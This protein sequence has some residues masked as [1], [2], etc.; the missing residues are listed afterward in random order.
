[1]ASYM[2][3]FCKCSVN[4]WKECIVS[5]SWLQS[6]AYFHS[7]KL[8]DRDAD[9][10]I[11]EDFLS[12]GFIIFWE[13][14]VTSVCLTCLV[15]K[16]GRPRTGLMRVLFES[17]GRGYLKPF[18]VVA[19]DPQVNCYGDNGRR[20]V[21][22]CQFCPSVVQLCYQKIKLRTVIAWMW[23]NFSSAC[24]DLSAVLLYAL[25]SFWPDTYQFFLWVSVCPA[26]HP[27]AFTLPVSSS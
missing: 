2:V 25:E 18:M 12:A 22:F 6:S 14:C 9:I 16:M 13:R 3:S 20:F 10:S 7:L 1:M 24:S 11:T 4:N 17:T 5:L 26:N 15:C 19:S 23:F 21:I 27:H 8:A